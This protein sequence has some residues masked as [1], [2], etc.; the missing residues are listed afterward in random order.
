MKILVNFISDLI[1]QIALWRGKKIP[2]PTK[3]SLRHTIHAKNHNI[4]ISADAVELSI[5]SDH[6]VTALRHVR[7]DAE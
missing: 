4:K 6:D 3:S 1:F 2:A 7:K 5:A